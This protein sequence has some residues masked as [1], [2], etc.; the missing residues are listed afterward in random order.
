MKD[1]TEIKQQI[2]LLMQ[3]Q[4]KQ[5]EALVHVISILHIT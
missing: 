1:M 2:N 4:T 5:E 3:E